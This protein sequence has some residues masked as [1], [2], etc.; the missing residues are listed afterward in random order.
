MASSQ[1]MSISFFFVR[2]WLRLNKNMFFPLPLLSTVS[3]CYLAE[4]LKLHCT[5]TLVTLDHVEYR[6]TSTLAVF[7]L[8]VFHTFLAA[9]T[10]TNQW[11]YLVQVSGKSV[12]GA[13]PCFV[14]LSRGYRAAVD[15]ACCGACVMNGVT[16]KAAN[17]VVT[18]ESVPYCQQ[19]QAIPIA[20]ALLRDPTVL[21]VVQVPA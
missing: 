6:W 15:N 17:S 8:T 10:T 20:N 18:L 14:L 7:Y 12:G 4:A 5:N 21:A 3:S 1:A 2:I 9:I 11:S 13:K 16:S 19:P